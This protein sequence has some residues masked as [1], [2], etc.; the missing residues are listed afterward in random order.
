MA[1]TFVG[2][3]L[4]FNSKDLDGWVT[5]EGK[6][7]VEHATI[8]CT[9]APAA[10]RASYES[11]AYEAQFEYR[12]ADKGLH[13]LFVHSKMIAGGARLVLTPAGALAGESADSGQARA[14]DPDKWI[15]V[16]LKVD[17][18]KVMVRSMTSRGEPLGEAEL[19]LPEGARG[20]LRFQSTEP[21][22][23]LRN[24]AA[25]ETDFRPM[26]DGRTL[27]GWEILYPKDPNDPGWVAHADGTIECR[28]RRSGWLRTLE[29]Y[30]DVIVRLEYQLPPSGN[31]GLFLRAPIEGRVSRIGLEFQLLDDEAYPKLKPAQHT[32]SVYDGIPPEVQVPAPANQWNAL[33]V[34]V[35]GKHVRTIL[36]G[37]QLYDA[38]LDDAKKDTNS[39]VRPL[40]TRRLEGFIG[41]QDHSTPVRFRNVRIRELKRSGKPAAGK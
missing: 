35:D 4:L 22:L 13:E 34:M 24:I 20:F 25:R 9:A 29:S 23:E 40:S 26:F 21:G 27:K 15:K 39:D 30:S 12:K 3:M 17:G 16:R 18:G 41:L 33:E 2:L 38:Q 32:G 6:W 1:M 37:V 14:G 31:S 7:A 5:L 19:T 8:V 10:I 36:N 28:G 11:D